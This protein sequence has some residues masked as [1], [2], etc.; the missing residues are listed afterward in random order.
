[1]NLQPI[2]LMEESKLSPRLAAPMSLAPL[3]SKSKATFK[4]LTLQSNA[5][6]GNENNF[7]SK[8]SQIPNM[9]SENETE[10]ES[11]KTLMP[12]DSHQVD[13][14]GALLG[15]ERSI[16]EMQTMNTRSPGPSVRSNMHMGRS[17]SPMDANSLMMPVEGQSPYA[18]H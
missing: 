1:M 9:E 3:A 17:K 6:G 11:A 7:D 18:A 12:G 13:E 14:I 5:I 8:L 16:A 2:D 10:F 4:P 15:Y